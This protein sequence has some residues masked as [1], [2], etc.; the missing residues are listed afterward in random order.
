MNLGE[1]LLQWKA[2]IV[3]VGALAAATNATEH[4]IEL[5]ALMSAINS[6]LAFDLRC[7][8]RER[9]LDFIKR[10]YPHSLPRARAELS[11]LSTRVVVDG[12]V[13]IDRAAR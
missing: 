7:E 6:S 8:V 4:T 1:L 5:R 12:E 3:G 13:P 11:E 10:N 9:L 2:A